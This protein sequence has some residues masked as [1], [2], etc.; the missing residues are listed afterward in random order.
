MNW[1]KTIGLMFAYA[2]F[3]VTAHGAGH[4]FGGN[5]A[6]FDDAG[7]NSAGIAVGIGAAILGLV[8]AKYGDKVK[9]LVQ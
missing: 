5:P 1:I 8:I 9:R 7:V 3:I 4:Y 6:S 2:A